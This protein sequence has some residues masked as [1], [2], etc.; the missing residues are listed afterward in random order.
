MLYIVQ[1]INKKLL[2]FGNTEIGKRIFYYS[3]VDTD[4]IIISSKVSFVKN[5]FKYF[6]G[7]KDDDKVIHYA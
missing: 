7:Y 5:G 2:I 4:K 1:K 6:I 3:K